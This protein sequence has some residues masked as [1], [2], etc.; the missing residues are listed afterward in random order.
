MHLRIVRPLIASATIAL[1]AC[2]AFSGCGKRGSAVESGNRDQVLHWGNLAEPTDL[3]PHVITSI[4]DANLTMQ[5]FEAL[6]LYDPKDLHPI[7]GVAESWESTPDAQTWTFHLRKNAKWSN[8]DPVTARDFV[9]A[10]QR[11]L[12]PKLGAEYAN[13]VTH[14]K[15]GAEYLSGKLTDFSQVGA[16]APDDY[17][18]VLTLWHP[19]PYLPHLVSHQA[20]FPVHRATIEKFGKIDDRG[21]AW[22]KPGNFVG[23]GPFVL[24]EWKPNQVIVM[25]KSPTYWDRD[26]VKLNE[27]HVYP[28]ENE[29]TE[30]A[31]F[32]AGQLHLTAQTPIEK[33][34]DYKKDPAGYLHQSTALSTYFYRFNV[35][36]PPLDDARVR[37]ALAMAID[38]QLIVDKVAKG[39]QE[40]AHNFVPP[41]TAG[42]NSRHGIPTDIPGAQKLLA[43]AGFPEGK[44]FPKLELLYNTTEGHRKI[45]EAIQQMW[46]KNLG[47]DVSLYNQEAKVWNDTMRQG[48]YQIARYAWGGDY[49]DPSTFL[50]IMTT[51]NGNNQTGW[52]NAEYDKL[53]DQARVTADNAKRYEYFQRCEEIL[54]QE[55]PLAFVYFYKRNI[56]MRPEVKGYYGN[57]LD[58]HTLKWVYLDPSAAKKS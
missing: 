30:E 17:T 4:Q 55:A 44:G 47:I 7:P 28:I 9:Y 38:Q 52:G 21:T 42:Y 13:M 11:I 22:T 25:K 32:R 41:N 39:G 26:V 14:L 54:A 6:T 56:L 12:S 24:T 10:F 36:K 53:I 40:P 19:L 5:L 51:G 8:G 34:A 27:V 46:R 16:K 37:R 48:N 15:N 23:N 2:F 49:L 50:D 43:E 58:L 1:L 45:A 57:L 31:A 33:I 29:T 3:D 20:W 18:L 35:R